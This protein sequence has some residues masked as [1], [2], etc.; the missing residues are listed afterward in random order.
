[1]HN[2]RDQLMSRYG[3]GHLSY[4]SLKQALG[5]IVQFDR[6]MK[7]ELKY[8]SDALD[9]GSLYDMMLFEPEKVSENY[10]FFND[11]ELI[12]SLSEKTKASKAPK[13]TKEYKE[14]VQKIH[15]DAEESNKMIVTEDM[16]KQAEDMIDRLNSC[17]LI[18]SHMSGQYQVEFLE[19]VNGVPVKGF[20]DCLGSNY[21]TDSKSTMSINK[22]RYSVR[23]F[24]YDIQAYIY[25]KVFGVDTF[26]WLAQEKTYPYTPAL[27]KC[28][29]NTLFQGEMKF[30]Q[31]THAIREFL[32]KGEDYDPSVEYLEF[33]I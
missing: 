28:S 22:F 19:E 6:Y 12:N 3:K 23:D 25:T 29:E 9:F 18:D 4:S 33:E 27:V 31:A 20:L 26:Y 5:D 32:N 14:A 15:L 24:S 1:M 10:L 11:R 30:D 16:Y 2:L 13:A 8:K 17:G 21:I 7:G